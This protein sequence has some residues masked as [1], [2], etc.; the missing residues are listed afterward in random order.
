M[1]VIVNGPGMGRNDVEVGR[2]TL[3]KFFRKLG[4]LEVA[5]KIIFYNEGVKLLAEESPFLADLTLLEERGVELL[6]CGTCLDHFNL[7]EKLKVGRATTMDEVV[8]IMTKAD[9]VVTL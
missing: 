4:F 6:A 1:V 5:A 9:K 8:D 2:K 3:G 7:M